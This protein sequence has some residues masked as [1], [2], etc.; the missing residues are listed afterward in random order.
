MRRTIGG[1][2]PGQTAPSQRR[3]RTE[4]EG[5]AFP[6]P[7]IISINARSSHHKLHQ[8]PPELPPHMAATSAQMA[9]LRPKTAATPAEKER[10]TQTWDATASMR[11]TSSPPASR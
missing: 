9:A 2:L 10:V 4:G 1:M 5:S 8:R 3:T 7:A 6:A 11:R